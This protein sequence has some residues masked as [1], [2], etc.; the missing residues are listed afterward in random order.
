MWHLDEPLAR[1]SGLCDD[2]PLVCMG[3]AGEW[4]TVGDDAWK[5]RMDDAMVACCDSTGRPRT[6]LHML[7]GAAVV[8][9]YPFH[10]VDSTNVARNH[11]LWADVSG[12][13][14]MIETQQAPVR[15]TPDGQ[16]ELFAALSEKR[17]QT[18][19]GML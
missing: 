3:S 7:R 10:S 6:N 13:G 11:H 15:W 5:R 9:L 14:R 18:T 12:R 16:G 4:A 17:G 19:I 1:L 2:W 8:G